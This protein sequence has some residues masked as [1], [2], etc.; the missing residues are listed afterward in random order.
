MPKKRVHEIAKEQGLSSKELLDKLHAAGVE[1][2][3]ASSSVDESQALEALGRNG[4]G[5]SA[6]AVLPESK[7]P[8][9]QQQPTTTPP[10]AIIQSAAP[11]RSR[12][13]SRMA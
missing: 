6:T 12:F 2:K 7:K 4:A 11:A 9:M 13:L 8:V 10:T 3:V 1:A 5:K